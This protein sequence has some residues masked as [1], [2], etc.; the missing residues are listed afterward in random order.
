MLKYLHAGA[1]VGV[2]EE[3]SLHHIV[4]L[5]EDAIGQPDFFGNASITVEQGVLTFTITEYGHEYAMRIVK[6]KGDY[7]VSIH[8]T[9]HAI[10]AMIETLRYMMDILD[11]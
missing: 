1:Y 2:Y 9:L 5:I 7:T 6:D 10:G 4:R 11:Y 3:A 8:G